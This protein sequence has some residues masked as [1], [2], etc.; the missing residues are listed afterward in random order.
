MKELNMKEVEQVGGGKYGVGSVGSTRSMNGIGP[1]TQVKVDTAVQGE[2]GK[3]T[4][5]R[6]VMGVQPQAGR[7]VV[8]AFGNC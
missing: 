5:L 6:I 2:L 1:G 7:P 8:S 4:N 3:R